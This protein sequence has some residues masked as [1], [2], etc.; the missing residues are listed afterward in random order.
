MVNASHIR[1]PVGQIS[2]E[3]FRGGGDPNA[4]KAWTAPMIALKIRQS[5]EQLSGDEFHVRYRWL[6]EA[7]AFNGLLDMA[8][9]FDADTLYVN[10]WAKSPFQQVS[11][12]FESARFWQPLE[13][14]TLPVKNLA[15]C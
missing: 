15:S 4:N 13:V 9:A 11:F 3:L 6:Q 2:Q 7:Q 10:N 1:R 5:L 14:E 8:P 12:S